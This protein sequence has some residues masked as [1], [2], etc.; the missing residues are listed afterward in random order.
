MW[1][2][3]Y[4]ERL[5]SVKN[6]LIADMKRKL[7]YNWE[8]MFDMWLSMEA[9]LEF[10]ESYKQQFYEQFERYMNKDIE[11][12]VWFAGKNLVFA[13][14][15]YSCHKKN[16]SLSDVMKY[17]EEFIEC[18]MGDF[19]NWCEEIGSRMYEESSDYERDFPEE[20]ERKENNPN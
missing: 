1:D 2:E 7:T 6:A 20:N 16:A 9:D 8:R 17:A 11:N 3:I 19:G 13:I 4:E 5:E 15:S 10:G 12:L 18:Q 14:T